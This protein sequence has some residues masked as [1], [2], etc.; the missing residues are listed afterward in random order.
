M[1]RFVERNK[2]FEAFYFTRIYINKSFAVSDSL[3]DRHLTFLCLFVMSKLLFQNVYKLLF[4]KNNSML[5]YFA[6][7]SSSKN[8]LKF[9]N[10][11]CL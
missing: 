5:S 10:D 8:M 7:L 3:T 2:V 11:Q 6:L 1:A 9:T 4:K